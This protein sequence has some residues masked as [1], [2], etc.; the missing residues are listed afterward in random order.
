MKKVITVFACLI[1]GAWLLP[2]AFGQ[3]GQ[4]PQPPQDPMG[5]PP[6]TSPQ[7]TPPTLPQAEPRPQQPDP[8]PPS[9]Q[10]PEPQAAP[11]SQHPN[12]STATSAGSTADAKTFMGTVIK[13]QEGYMLRAAD[14]QYK[15]DD[16]DR[17]GQFD[18]KNVKIQGT[19]DSQ[20]NTIHVQTIESSPSM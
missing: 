8:T 19:L 2:A 10:A 16:Q 9:T 11:E 1:V 18:G 6:V 3:T 4:Q 13:G 14:Q 5:P 7:S 12:D 20:T 15:L 17:A